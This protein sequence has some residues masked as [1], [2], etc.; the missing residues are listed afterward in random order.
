M[1]KLLSER[2]R[3]LLL[4]LGILT[5]TI[6]LV[7]AILVVTATIDLPGPI[8][9]LLMLTA[10]GLSIG[11]RKPHD[12]TDAQQHVQDEIYCRAMNRL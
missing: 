11:A 12:D 6:G 8:P 1:E 9:L 3:K 7:L 2:S 10:I 4:F 5:G